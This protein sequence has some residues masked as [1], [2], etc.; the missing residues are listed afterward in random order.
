MVEERDG[1]M[2][3]FEH[4]TELFMDEEMDEETLREKLTKYIST[5]A[6]GLY[7]HREKVSAAASPKLR[8][9]PEL[10]KDIQSRLRARQKDQEKKQKLKAAK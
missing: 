2:D 5:E 1:I 10:E 8:T 4:A 3:L 9:S 7:G 6:A